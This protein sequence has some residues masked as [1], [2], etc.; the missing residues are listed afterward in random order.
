[1]IATAGQGLGREL[2][3]P[4]APLLAGRRV[5]YVPDGV[6]NLVPLAALVLAEGPDGPRDGM[7]VPSAAILG[8]LRSGGGLTVTDEV[9][10]D[11][12]FQRLPVGGIGDLAEAEH[13]ILVG[14]ELCGLRRGA[15]KRGGDEQGC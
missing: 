3:G 15:G 13:Q 11:D 1:M 6:L 7:R 12:F 5:V 14:F 8:H 2:L 10:G 9:L 4:V